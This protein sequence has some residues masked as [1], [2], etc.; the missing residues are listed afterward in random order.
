MTYYYPTRRRYCSHCGQLF[1]PKYANLKLCYPCYVKRDKALD[2]YDV[3]L[4]EVSS[5]RRQLIVANR[6]QRRTTT[7]PDAPDKQTLRWMIQQLHPDKHTN[8]DYSTAAVQWL[9]GLRNQRR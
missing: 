9:N 7:A 5:L 4:A 1:T 8:A 6:N 3:L 2:A